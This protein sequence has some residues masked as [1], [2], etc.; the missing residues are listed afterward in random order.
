MDSP[1][2]SKL[3]R[4]EILLVPYRQRP[5]TGP[6]QFKGDWPGYFIRGDEIEGRITIYVNHLYEKL[7][8]H[9]DEEVRACLGALIDLVSDMAECNVES[10]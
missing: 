10:R 5:W 7:R 4:D 9:E 6:L 8:G 3:R 2:R 1:D